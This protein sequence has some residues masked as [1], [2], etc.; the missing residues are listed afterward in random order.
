MMTIEILV[1]LMICI[2]LLKANNNDI[3]NGDIQLENT[4][5]YL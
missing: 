4:S 2:I 5:K 1:G 3:D